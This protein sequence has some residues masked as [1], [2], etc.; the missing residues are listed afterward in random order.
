[1]IK[2]ASAYHG[3]FGP[4]LSIIHFLNPFIG[5][6]EHI[7]FSKKLIILEVDHLRSPKQGLENLLYVRSSTQFATNFK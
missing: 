7:V 3:T 5:E 4:P 6:N 1:M 2:T